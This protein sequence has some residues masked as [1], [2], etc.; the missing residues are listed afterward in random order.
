MTPITEDKTTDLDAELRRL[1][2]EVRAEHEELE[3]LRAKLRVGRDGSVQLAAMFAVLLA[4]AALLAVAFKLNDSQTPAS[5]PMHGSGAV[6]GGGAASAPL[7]AGIQITHVQRGCHAW[8]INGLTTPDGTIRIASGGTLTITDNDVMPHRLVATGGPAARISKASMDHMGAQ[9]TV[10]FSKPGVYS[11]TTQ[12][13]EDYTSGIETTGPD[14]H[15]RLK[16]VVS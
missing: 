12:A 15:L 2:D 1:S 7:A 16:V 13:G 14:N 5:M 3:E 10:T 11:F 8:V 4:L 6:A 9:S